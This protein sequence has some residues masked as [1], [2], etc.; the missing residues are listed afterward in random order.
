MKWQDTTPLSLLEVWPSK[1]VYW[2]LTCMLQADWYV[3][4]QAARS[5]YTRDSIERHPDR[6]KVIRKHARNLVA[7]ECIPFD[8]YELVIS[9]DAILQVPATR[10]TLF[11]YYAQ[12]NW[13]RLYSMSLQRPVGRYDLFLAH[14]LDA[15]YAIGALPQAIA[16]PYV[17]APDFARSTFNRHKDE[18]AWIDWRTLNTLAGLD[19]AG[20]WNFE[21]EAAAK[22]VPDIL[23]M[24]I[25][26]RGKPHEQTYGF[27]DPPNWGDAAEYLRELSECRYYI[28]VGRIGGAGQG[29]AEAASMGCLCIGQVSKIYHRLICHGSCLCEDIA[30]MPRR[31]RV[32]RQSA[33][34][35]RE[36]LACQDEALRRYF[37]HGPLN[38]L[39]EAARIKSSTGQNTREIGTRAV[40]GEIPKG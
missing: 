3:I 37:N 26:Y 33:D 38:L 39:K 23:N 9:F 22:R 25:S 27:A 4:P 8:E 30:E 11:A 14:M 29:L 32:L 34:L 21:T 35:Q 18:R 36:V 13:D 6:A 10:S 5:D 15:D 31:L 40:A 20:P 1:A 24:P 19:L 17:H 12:E 16:F 7:V 28:G 2:E